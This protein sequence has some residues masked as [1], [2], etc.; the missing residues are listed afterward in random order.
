M[1]KAIAC[2]LVAPLAAGVADCHVVPLDVS[3][4]PDVLGATTC[5]AD[6]PLPSR[7]LFAVNVAAPVPPLATGRVPVTFAVIEQY[8]VDVEPVPPLAIGSA[9]PE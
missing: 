2:P 3:T 4:F 6:V 5:S 7:T 1:E 9:V 8:V